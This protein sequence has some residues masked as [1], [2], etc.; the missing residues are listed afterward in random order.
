MNVAYLKM[1][2]FSPL[3]VGL[4]QYMVID[5]SVEFWKDSLVDFLPVKF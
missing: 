4:D 3:F 1:V 2:E 5:W